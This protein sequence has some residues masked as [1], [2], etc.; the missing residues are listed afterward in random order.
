MKNHR[1]KMKNPFKSKYYFRIIDRI[2]TYEDVK[3]ELERKKMLVRQ[4][5]NPRE[6]CALIVQIA[7]VQNKLDLLRALL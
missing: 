6:Y 7:E 1:F 5:I 2:A 3:A 4:S